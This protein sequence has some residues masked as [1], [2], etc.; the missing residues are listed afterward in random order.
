MNTKVL[1][2]LKHLNL[3]ENDLILAIN[4]SFELFVFVE[5]FDFFF[6]QKN[7]DLNFIYMSKYEKFY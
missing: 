2:N 3:E 6:E 7:N 5:K 4:N 1:E